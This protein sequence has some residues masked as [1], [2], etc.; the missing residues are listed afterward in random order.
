MRTARR[1]KPRKVC[2]V[3]FRITKLVAKFM[4]GSKGLTKSGHRRVRLCL[5]GKRIIISRKPEIIP[6]ITK[7]EGF[8]EENA[9][10]EFGIFFFHIFVCPRNLAEQVALFMQ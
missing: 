4:T 1:K 7:N 10:L 8:T 9:I 6:C 3:F 2:F 5:T